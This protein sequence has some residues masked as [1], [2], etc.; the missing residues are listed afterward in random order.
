MGERD[1]GEGQSPWSVEGFVTW[2][3]RR[4]ETEEKEGR[5]AAEGEEKKG[6]AFSLKGEIAREPKIQ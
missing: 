5:T 6:Q 2:I 3:K 1:K 4:G